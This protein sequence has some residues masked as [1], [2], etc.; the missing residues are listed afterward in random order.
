MIMIQQSDY[1]LQLTQKAGNGTEQQEPLNEV[2]ASE[3]CRRLNI[4]YVPYYLT[5]RDDKYFCYCPDMIDESTELVPMDAV[6]QD[7]HLI[8]GIDDWYADFLK[9]LKRLSEEKKVALIKKLRERIEET[10]SILASYKTE[11]ACSK[12]KV[13]NADLVYAALKRNPKQTKEEVSKATGLSR[14]TITRTYREL[15]KQGKIH[16]VGSNKTGYWEVF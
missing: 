1:D 2:L 16:R 11:A 8:D 13:S 15:E 12:E 4:A 7:L 3:I 5:I 14:A 9:P 6:Y 10:K